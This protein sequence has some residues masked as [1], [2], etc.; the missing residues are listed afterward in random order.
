[1]VT[2]RPC[3]GPNDTCWGGGLFPPGFTQCTTAIPPD[4]LR[5]ACDTTLPNPAALKLVVTVKS[6]FFTTVGVPIKCGFAASTSGV[7]VKNTRNAV[8]ISRLERNL[9]SCSLF[10]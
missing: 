3:K 8:P 2:T 9:L 6:G 1:M 7:A 4:E 5:N 10:K